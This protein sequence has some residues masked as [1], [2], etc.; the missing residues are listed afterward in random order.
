MKLHICCDDNGGGGG[1]VCM[2]PS[3]QSPP[4]GRF[5]FSSGRFLNGNLRIRADLYLIT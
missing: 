1:V 3:G 5:P 2:W 4:S